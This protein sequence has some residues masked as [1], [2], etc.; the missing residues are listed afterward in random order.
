MAVLKQVNALSLTDSGERYFAAP[1]ITMSGG[2]V[3]TS[4]KV[5]YGNNSLN[6]GVNSWTYNQTQANGN[7]MDG[8]I[9]G[10]VWL[11][12]GA[13]PDSAGANP[14]PIFEWGTNGNGAARRRWGIDNDGDLISANKYTNFNHLETWKNQSETESFQEGQWNHFSVSFYGANSG[15]ATRRADIYING[16]RNYYTNGTHFSGTFNVDSDIL[17]G[18]QLA[19]S[20]GEHNTTWATPT[21]MYLDNFYLDSAGN[22]ASTKYLYDSD[23]D[24]GRYSSS[25]LVQ[26]VTFNNVTATASANLSNSDKIE[27]ITMTNKGFGYV[28]APTVLIAKPA[29]FKD[30]QVGDIVTFS[31]KSD[32]TILKGE[33][34]AWNRDT[35]IL[36]IMKL[37][38]NKGEFSEPIANQTLTIDRNDAGGL[39]TKVV[40]RDDS[41]QQNQEFV[42]LVGD[43]L[44]F[45]EGNPFGEVEYTPPTVA[46]TVVVQDSD[47]N[48]RVSVISKKK[49]VNWTIPT[50]GWTLNRDTH[51]QIDILRGAM[52][53]T[54]HT[55]SAL[56]PYNRF[57]YL[58]SSLPGVTIDSDGN[59]YARVQQHT[60]DSDGWVFMGMDN[61]EDSSG[62]L[63]IGYGYVAKK[64]ITVDTYA[65][66]KIVNDS[67]DV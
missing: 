66:N 30:F 61:D 64:Q 18:N 49:I 23:N 65:A 27:S 50:G 13:L 43:F 9:A 17:F 4:N 36:D 67:G 25:T 55:D 12:S 2:H 5:R 31:A 7:S 11:D 60:P 58:M 37:S 63:A 45:S 47:E 52:S 35:K 56:H 10:W 57:K 54:A 28:S 42:D 20:F 53:D 1:L 24:S 39:V 6:A 33:V 14:I 21:G 46:S 44:D 38:S 3:V 59:G 41:D 32:G 62:L 26:H 15:F 40:T 16:N 29:G 22:T 34:A 19:G 48:Y 51:D 8:F